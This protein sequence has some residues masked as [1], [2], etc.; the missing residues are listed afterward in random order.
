VT[1]IN[2][3]FMK[4]FNQTCKGLLSLIALVAIQTLK[5]NATI[6][7]TTQPIIAD[8][9]T[10][11]LVIIDGKKASE[12]QLKTLMNK[13]QSVIILT[14]PQEIKRYGKGFTKVIVVKTTSDLISPSISMDDVNT[15][16][17]YQCKIRA[18][19]IVWIPQ[20]H[21]LRFYGNVWIKDA[22]GEQKFNGAFSYA[23]KGNQ[24]LLLINN[25]KQDLSRKIIP[26]KNS[27]YELTCLPST[28]A[29]KKFGMRAKNGAFEMKKV[30]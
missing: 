30:D 26:D 16:V 14:K 7:P 15:N 17:P 9:S 18:D 19:T 6:S 27:T 11:V 23:Q 20:L 25:I 10:K 13:S 2:E 28:Y 5:A 1:E 12:K 3:L 8:S 4:H 22:N 29:K 21:T 24:V